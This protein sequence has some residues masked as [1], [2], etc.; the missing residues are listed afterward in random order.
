MLKGDEQEVDQKN[1]L[2][3]IENFEIYCI[4]DI[5]TNVYVWCVYRRPDEK[6]FDCS[7]L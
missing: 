7:Y 1:K 4:K 3:N 2:Y 6:K 5:E